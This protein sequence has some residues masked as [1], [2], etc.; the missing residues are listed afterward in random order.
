[1]GRYSHAIYTKEGGWPPSIE[2]LMAEYSK[3]QGH[4]RSRLPPFSEE[5]RKLVQGM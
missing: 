4:S 5:E 2:K 3:K 1:M